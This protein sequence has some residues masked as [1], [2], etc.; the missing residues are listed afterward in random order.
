MFKKAGYVTGGFGKWG[1]GFPASEGVPEKQGFD[2]FYGYNCQRQ[3]HNYFP[4]HLWVNNKRIDLS[5]TITIQTQYAPDLIQK[6]ALEFIKENKKK[7]FF[8][9][10][11]YTLP[12]AA[13]QLPEGDPVFKYYK[14]KFKEGPKPI[15]VWD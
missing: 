14:K 5:N 3:S 1:L 4:D 11:P 9:Y 2:E 15:K 12:H 7:P 10:L 6:K 8:L 13:L